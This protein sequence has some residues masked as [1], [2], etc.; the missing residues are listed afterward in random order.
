MAGAAGGVAETVETGAGRAGCRRAGRAT[1]EPPAPVSGTAGAAAAGLDATFEMNAG[2]AGTRGRSLEA[3]EGFAAGASAACD[4][5]ICFCRTTPSTTSTPTSAIADAPTIDPT[6]LGRQRRR[7]RLPASTPPEIPRASATG[8]GGVNETRAAPESSSFG[9][10]QTSRLVNGA[11]AS[12]SAPA[13]GGRAAGSAASAPA[14]MSRNPTGRS[15]AIDASGTAACVA[16]WCKIALWDS[17]G[18]GFR[19]ETELVEDRAQR[20]DVG[21]LIDHLV[22]AGLLGRH[23][24][25]GPDHRAG[26][27][28]RVHLVDRLQLGDAEVEHLE[29]I[30][31]VLP[32]ADEQI[33]RLEVAVDDPRGVR[34]LH[35]AARLRHQI[36]GPPDR[37]RPLAPEE[38]GE[39]LAD[40][41]LHHDVGRAVLGDAE[42]D[43]GR[44]VLALER[45]GRL[46]LTLEPRQDVP[47]LGEIATHE[48]HREAAPHDRVLRLVHHAHPPFS[49]QADD[50]VLGADELPHPRDRDRPAGHS[51][52]SSAL[53][54]A[55][56]STACPSI[57]R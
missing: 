2:R 1:A 7:A 29:E 33:L 14:T 39:A 51:R 24:R 9:A 11:S 18:C 4:S 53:R 30:G 21:A 8:D 55:S 57:S 20:V 34:D 12:T 54:S 3:S 35:A 41:V 50:P 42:V 10:G 46:C 22:A 25:D 31:P 17:P 49:Q 44:H 6:R 40:Q 32:P 19:P 16:M 28:R 56:R 5:A 36:G 38:R 52:R 43:G 27:R 48:L 23:V 47:P 15:G 37:Q 26:A 13:D 45:P